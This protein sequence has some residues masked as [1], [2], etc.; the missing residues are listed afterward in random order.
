MHSVIGIPKRKPSS[1]LF[2]GKAA[3]KLRPDRNW[4]SGQRRSRRL[5][6]SGLSYLNSMP[7]GTTNI[8]SIAE[9]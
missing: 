2:E 9:A 4:E 6:S 7:W 1:V 5:G 8:G 3:L